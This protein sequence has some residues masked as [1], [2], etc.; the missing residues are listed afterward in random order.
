M[1]QFGGTTRTITVDLASPT[2]GYEDLTDGEILGVG[3]YRTPDRNY[4]SFIWYR[5][6]GGSGT[7]PFK[8]IPI[9]YVEDL[10]ESTVVIHL[11]ASVPLLDGVVYIPMLVKHATLANITDSSTANVFYRYRPYQTVD[12]LPSTLTVEIMSTPDFLYVSNL[13]TG[14][15]NAV[16]K[17]P[18]ENPIEHIPVNDD[19]LGTDNIFSNVDDLD[20][21][22]YSIDT[23]FVKLPALISRKIGE[24]VVLSSPNNVGDR[25]G[26]SFYSE[27]SE[28]FR[29][30]GE[31]LL[32]PVP[33]KV[34]VPM[35]A[36]IRS[37]LTA[38]FIRGELVLL[39]FSKAFKA[40][41]EDE[42]GIFDDLNEEYS[43]GYFE[44]ADTSIGVYRLTNNPTVR[45]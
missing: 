17:D 26:R 30:Q 18:Y 22:S 1:E 11:D 32:H 35:L 9:D 13:G 2:G 29:F 19:E 6:T 14:G 20:F 24:D 45:I 43:P 7:E 4:Q 28:T 27:C 38:P 12:S 36:R 33:R 21:T 34:F 37:D 16:P 25:L 41:V 8:S 39:V 15:T 23:G 3:S 42:I 44:T 10:G 31:A 40:R 5:A